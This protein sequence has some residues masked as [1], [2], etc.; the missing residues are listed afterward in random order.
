[1]F[2]DGLI[3]AV[4]DKTDDGKII[5]KSGVMAIVFKGG[6]VSSGDKIQL[7]RPEQPQIA[8]EPI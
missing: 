4:L 1:M 7:E 2:Q 8:M 3:K 6:L 5:R